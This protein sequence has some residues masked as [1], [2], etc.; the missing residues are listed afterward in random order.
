M[1][2]VSHDA[3]LSFFSFAQKALHGAHRSQRNWRHG[4]LFPFPMDPG[5]IQSPA[6][7]GQLQTTS[8]IFTAWGDPSTR[9]CV[10]GG[11]QQE[12]S[13][14]IT[15]D[16]IPYKGL[17]CAPDPGGWAPGKETRGDR[18][19]SPWPPDTLCSSRCAWCHRWRPSACGPP[20][21]LP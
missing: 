10:A 20:P 14:D 16:I 9:V 19:G 8:E 3:K 18:G 2:V 15:S 7:A 4:P 5:T 6:L 1:V 12:Y 13:Y 21:P 11:R 17:L